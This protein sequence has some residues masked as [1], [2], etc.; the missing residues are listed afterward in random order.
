MEILMIVWN[1]V[2]NV[3]MGL[4]DKFLIAWIVFGIL[5]FFVWNWMY[6]SAQDKNWV[7]R[8]TVG[9]FFILWLVSVALWVMAIFA[10]FS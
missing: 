6:D 2:K 1:F 8:I 10:K 9:L 7:A 4:G 3:V 5:L